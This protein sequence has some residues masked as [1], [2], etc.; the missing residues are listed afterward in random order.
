M[1]Q[2]SLFIAAQLTIAAAAMPALRATILLEFL[3]GY[4]ADSGLVR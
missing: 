3:A 4:D 1:G 2:Q